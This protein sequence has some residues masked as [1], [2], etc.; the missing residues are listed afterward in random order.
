MITVPRYKFN[1]CKQ[2]PIIGGSKFFVKEELIYFD[3]PIMICLIDSNQ[4]SKPIQYHIA[5]FLN[6]SELPYSDIGHAEVW[7]MTSIDTNRLVDMLEGGYPPLYC[8]TEPKGYVV[9]PQIRHA[10]FE[11]LEMYEVDD[12]DHLYQF[13]P[14]SDF[15]FGKKEFDISQIHKIK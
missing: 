7:Y 6:Y 11:L 9:V 3:R 4:P 15:L 12:T 1:H 10:K 8:L 5:H 13:F 2:I 14:T